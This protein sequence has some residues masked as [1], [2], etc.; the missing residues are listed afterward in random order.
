MLAQP[1]YANSDQWYNFTEDGHVQFVVE[2]GH[3]AAAGDTVVVLHGGWGADHSYLIDPLAPLAE[4]Y[5]FV[6]YDQRGSLL[7][8]APDSTISL[9]RL[10]ADLEDLRQSLGLSRMTLAAHS[11]GNALAYAYLAQHPER[12]RGLVLVGAVFPTMFTNEPNMSFIRTVWPEADSSALASATEA[13]FEGVNARAMQEI[14]EEGLIPDSLR[15]VAPSELNLLTILS[16]KEWTHAWRISFA[17]VNSCSGENWREMQG[18]MVYY[19][20]AVAEAVL[21]DSLYS[22]RTETFWPALQRFTGPVRVIMGTCDY[23][24]VGPSVWPR[25]T[26]RLQ[27]GTLTV[28]EG[29]GH[30]LWMDRRELFRDALDGALREATE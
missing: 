8:P 25:I 27:D 2:I 30:S 9:E 5:R 14:G 17:A 22:E 10:V 24:D 11:M 7:S 28:V 3:A 15:N 16:D 20:Q 4:Q 13:F 1:R 12:V 18:G 6:F 26:E 29:A 19:K 23:V 21:G